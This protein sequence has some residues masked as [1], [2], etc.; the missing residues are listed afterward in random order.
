[1]KIVVRKDVYNELIKSLFNPGVHPRGAGGKFITKLAPDTG[2]NGGPNIKDDNKV[3]IRNYEYYNEEGF[4]ICISKL[5]VSQEIAEMYKNGEFGYKFKPG[6]VSVSALRKDA[7]KRNKAIK[8]DET[9]IPSKSFTYNDH[10]IF[11]AELRK[12]FG[13]I[14]NHLSRNKITCPSIDNKKVIIN[15]GLSVGHLEEHEI[16]IQHE[17][18]KFIHFIPD[19]IQKG[20]LLAKQLIPDGNGGANIR[21]DLTGCCKVDGKF[22][23][24]TLILEEDKNNLLHITLFDK[25]IQKS[26]SMSASVGTLDTLTMK[27]DLVPCSNTLFVY[28]IDYLSKSLTKQDYY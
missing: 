24:V 6:L 27:A 13:Q 20:E 17:R 25:E 11:A 16:S 7:G 26:I 23:A 21:Y 4:K 9:I 14:Q 12:L 19:L 3:T 8:D 28:G 2:A 15:V 1:M 5:E 10:K 18:A 22:Y